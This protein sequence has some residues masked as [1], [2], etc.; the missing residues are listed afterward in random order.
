MACFSIWYKHQYLPLPVYEVPAIRVNTTKST[1]TFTSV[2]LHQIKAQQFYNDLSLY[3]LCQ[4]L[5]KKVNVKDFSRLLGD[6][7]V[8]FKADLISK[9]FS[10]KPSKFKYFSSQCEPSEKYT[11]STIDKM[12][13][14]QMQQYV[15]LTTTQL[16]RWQNIPNET[17]HDKLSIA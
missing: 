4:V 5:K 13:L 12:F 11:G 3:Q 14:K 15:F 6:F 10:R 16:L 2:M 17:S 9:D 7:Q 1:Y 8:L